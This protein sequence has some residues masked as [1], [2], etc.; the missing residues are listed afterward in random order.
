MKKKEFTQN[1]SMKTEIDENRNAYKHGKKIKKQGNRVKVQ[2]ESGR[3]KI[4]MWVNTKTKVIET[5]Y[6]KN[7]G[8]CIIWM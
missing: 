6:P 5:A 3:L 4:E 8:G 1:S 7:E 2:G